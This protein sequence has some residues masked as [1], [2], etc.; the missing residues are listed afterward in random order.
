MG[1]VTVNLYPGVFTPKG[2][3]ILEA[4]EFSVRAFAYSTGVLGLAVDNAVGGFELLP[5]QG[6]QIW[7]AHFI[8]E[9]LK[10]HTS[11]EEPEPT[12]DFLATYGAFL[13]HCGVTAM[14]NPAEDDTH[15]QHGELPNMP[16][17]RAYVKLGHDRDGGYI[18]AGGFVRVRNSFSFDY[19]ANPEVCLYAGESVM[20]ITM[21]ITNNRESPMQ[22]MY[23][24]H[25]NFHPRDGAQLIYSA[26][27]D[28]AHVKVFRDIPD[29]LPNEKASRLAS[30]MDTIINEPSRHHK[31][32]ES[33]QCYDPE[34]VMAIDYRTDKDGWSHCMQYSEKYA[35]YAAFRKAELPVGIRWISRTGDEDA[36]GMVLPATGDHKGRAMARRSGQIKE[37]PP[38]GSI[39]FACRAGCL[40]PA[41][42]LEMKSH[43][44]SAGGHRTLPVTFS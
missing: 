10:M 5:Y 23:L 15:P 33:W 25:I 7:R 22:Y 35:D 24:C 18:C 38:H 16:Y 2:N 28:A 39:E 44:E 6:Q 9:E 31:I 17:D 34:V 36:M 1:T 40:L 14:G 30:C 42:A 11:F 29:G 19:T 26:P 8:G 21:G 37:L 32:G 3:L 4:G 27:T 12:R 20:H 43:I 41:K 13:L